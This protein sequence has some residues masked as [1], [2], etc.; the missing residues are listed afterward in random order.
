[1]SHAFLHV[2]GTPNPHVGSNSPVMLIGGHGSLPWIASEWVQAVRKGL[3]GVGV[4]IEPLTT[5]L[6]S[7]GVG[8]SDRAR[9]EMPF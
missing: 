8:L 1:M 4:L 3:S 7:A 6:V 9:T 5:D 2:T